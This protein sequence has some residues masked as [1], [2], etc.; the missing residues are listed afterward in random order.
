MPERINIY[1]ART[2]FSKIV[3]RAEHGETII[4]ARNNVPIVELRPVK[5]N[6]EEVMDGFRRLRD[7]IRARNGGDGILR[8][9]ESWRDLIREEHKY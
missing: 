1:D 5:R 2:H 3:E 8:H 4:I 7:R 6:P 9:G